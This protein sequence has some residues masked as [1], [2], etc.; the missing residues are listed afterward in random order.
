MSLDASDGCAIPLLIARPVP[1]FGDWGCRDGNFGRS[2]WRGGRSRKDTPRVTYR[3]RKVTPFPC[4][5]SHRSSSV[6]CRAAGDLQRC[7]VVQMRAAKLRQPCA[8][9]RHP[10]CTRNPVPALRSTSAVTTSHPS[11][12]PCLANQPRRLR[13]RASRQSHP[14]GGHQSSPDSTRALPQ[15]H[16]RIHPFRGPPPHHRHPPCLPN[17]S[18]KYPPS[19]KSR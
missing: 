13:V 6:A 12:P 18:S 8:Q 14:L 10:S 4:A 9:R 17:E 15:H 5:W 1:R 2:G 19:C 16:R 3:V 7:S 11:Q